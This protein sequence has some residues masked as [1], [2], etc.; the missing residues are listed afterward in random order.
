MANYTLEQ[1]RLMAT[2]L[3]TQYAHEED[4]IEAILDLRI[5]KKKAFAKKTY[6]QVKSKAQ[7]LHY[8]LLLA[9]IESY[10]PS[11]KR[12][13]EKKPTK[14]ELA[15]QARAAMFAEMPKMDD[16]K[17]KALKAAIDEAKDALKKKEAAAKKRRATLAKKRKEA[18]QAAGK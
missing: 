1:E 16:A 9:G 14:A 11:D 6:R 13:A 5:G 4:L 18:E 3:K 7:N 17:A 12:P 2:A 15:A 8:E 10:F